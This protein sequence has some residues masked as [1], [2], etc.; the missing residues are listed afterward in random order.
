MG[1]RRMMSKTVTQTQRFLTLPLEAQAFY[2]H[3]LQNTDDDGVCEA[4]MI[5]RLTGLTEDILDILEE[6]ELVKQL[7]DELVYHITDFHEQNYIDMRRYNESKYVGLLYEY[8]ILTTKEY[9][10]LS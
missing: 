1:N 6:A 5:L 4:Y 3:M 8:D 10:D 9:H 2:F 7:N